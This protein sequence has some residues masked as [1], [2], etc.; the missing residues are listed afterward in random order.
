MSSEPVVEMGLATPLF[1]DELSMVKQTGAITH[2]VFS[3]RQPEIGGAD[4]GKF[5]RAVQ[6]RLIVPT[7]QLNT[8][9]RAMLAREAAVRVHGDEYGE[10]VTH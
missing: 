9:A 3:V 8:M 1:V 7:D 4:R 2:L 6:M 10:P 5:I